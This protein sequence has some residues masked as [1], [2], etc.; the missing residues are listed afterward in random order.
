M[1]HQTNRIKQTP[2]QGNR[3][4]QRQQADRHASTFFS[5]SAMQYLLKLPMGEMREPCAIPFTRRRR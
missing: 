4:D 2:R 1:P 5:R 3:N